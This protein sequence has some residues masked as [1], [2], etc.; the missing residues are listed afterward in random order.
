[1]VCTSCAEFEQKVNESKRTGNGLSHDTR[2]EYHVEHEA[3][4]LTLGNAAPDIKSSF[5]LRPLTLAVYKMP[6]SYV[7]GLSQHCS[8]IHAP[9]EV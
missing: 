7:I 4:D 2:I 1:M 6:F 3:E 5:S 9:L 8:L